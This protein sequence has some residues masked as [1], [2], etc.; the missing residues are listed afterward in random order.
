MKVL[1]T[2][3]HPFN[4]ESINPSLEAIKLL[5]DKIGD[6][7]LIKQD[8]EV[9]YDKSFNTVKELIDEYHPD[10]ILLVGEA[11]RRKSVTIEKV[12]INYIDSNIKDNDGVLIK[13]SKIYDTDIYAYF[14]TLD[15][16]SIKDKVKDIEIS[17]SAGTF[18]CNYLFY[19]T[20]DYTKGTNTKVGFV[21]VP[22][23]KE[24]AISKDKDIPYMELSKIKEV[25]YKVIES[26]S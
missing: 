1:I 23:I 14:T 8:V 17:Y 13:H 15:L 12:A 19:K 26:L 7:E 22:Y 5:P 2:G 4:N 20:L 3:F 10:Y 11:G 18:V 21:H 6:F 16:V 25:L 24:Q 9:S